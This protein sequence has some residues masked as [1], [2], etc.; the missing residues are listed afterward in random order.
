M[1]EENKEIK[2]VKKKVIK[3]KKAVT[4]K[5]EQE[6]T[7]EEEI[8]EKSQE[9]QLVS[10]NKQEIKEEVQVN[11]EKV[12]TQKRPEKNNYNKQREGFYNR[13]RDKS[14]KRYYSSNYKESTTNKYTDERKSHDDE[15]KKV[16]HRKV[17]IVKKGEKER[18]LVNNQFDK[19]PH[20]ESIVEKDVSG[21]GKHR[22]NF[23][24][25]S[26]FNIEIKE[27]S[28][29]KEEE[30]LLLKMQDSIK[31]KNKKGE[32]VI[33]E[34]IEIGEI[35]KISDLAKKMNLKAAEIIQK[36][37]ELGV[38]ATL[39]DT[40]DADTAIIVASEFNCKVKVKNLKEEVEIKEDE[41]TPE[42]LKPRPPVVT[43]MGHV[44]HGKTSLLDAIR[45]SSITATETG[46][47]TQ[48]IGAY[49]VTIE[50][51]SITFI[52]TPG[53]EAF[54]SM[55]A[56]GASVTDIVVLVVS[57]V[58]GVMPQTVEA[59]NHAKAAKV[60]IIVAVNKSDLPGYNFEKVKQQLSDHGLIPEDW[61]GDTLYV[62][63]SALK[64]EGIKNL[65]EAIL[66]QADVMELKANP[67]K[68]GVA[69]VIE[70]K[71]DIGKGAI[72]TLIVKNGCI[73]VGDYFVAG[74]TMG[75]VRGMFDDNGRNIK[76]A[77]PSDAVEI[78]GFDNL[79][80]AG[81]KFFVV[82]SEEFAKSIAEKRLSL[83][84]LEESQNIKKIIRQAA[85][86]KLS[87]EKYKEIKVIIKADVQGS[88]EAIKFGLE[89]LSTPEVKVT[90]IHAGVGPVIESDVLLT[91]A[92]SRSSDAKVL[93]LAFR[94][95]VDNKAKEKADAE[96]IPIKRFN[97]IYEIIDYIS[98]MVKGLIKPEFK[99]T[100][101]GVAEIKEIF[102]IKDVGK[103]AG[104]YVKSGFIK[105]NEKVRIFRDQS[106][107]W[108]G[109]I[110]MLKRVKDSVDEVQEGFECG[111]SFVNFENFKKGDIIE[112]FKVEEISKA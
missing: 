90:V 9:Q 57:G 88:L 50:K 25:K 17:Y 18:Q 87:S 52:D 16:H 59:L 27:K 73:K 68:R 105:A 98:D 11:E 31:K 111:I 48:H 58:E 14:D 36:L 106:L 33:P 61:G 79:P 93:I 47:I 43:I 78:M 63:V 85:I 20:V 8:V 69:Y 19:K 15:N 1:P 42:N 21:K 40:I 23:V 5:Q 4:T 24:D 12:V 92:D 56:R 97:I 35:I 28:K 54:T 29:D 109:K 26:K 10:E 80:E 89:K 2:K 46:G 95:R 64:K 51:G 81:D 13:Y 49:K 44:D 84:K 101:I 60:P 34:E 67:N 6:K 30:I 82:E 75:R 66:L 102:K 45:N 22:T 83:K 55:R 77:L 39:N 32:Y 71:M 62:K 65:L 70:S 96:N 110:N 41:D 76:L 91:S 108:Q 37:I 100:I 94:V 7:T 72:A 112:C 103:V 86:D 99:E 107:I 38:T 3:L 53:H 74:T 104:C